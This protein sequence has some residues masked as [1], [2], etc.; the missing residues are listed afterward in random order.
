MGWKLCRCDFQADT[1]IALICQGS[2]D[3]CIEVV[4]NDSDLLAYESIQRLT[5]PV[6]KHRELTTFEKRNVLSLLKLRSDRHLLLVCILTKNDYFEGIS[7][8]GVFNNADIVRD[9]WLD[10]VGPVKEVMEN[11]VRAY[12]QKIAHPQTEFELYSNA[13]SA[14]VDLHE[15]P[16]NDATPSAQTSDWVGSVLQQIEK[17]KQSRIH[18]EPQQSQAQEGPSQLRW[19]RSKYKSKND[20]I[21]P[22]YT[23]HTVKD[24]H[25]APKVDPK[26]LKK[27]KVDPPRPPKQSSNMM[28]VNKTT[29]TVT[30]P[31]PSNPPPKDTRI[32]PGKPDET[33]ESKVSSHLPY[34]NHDSRHLDG[35]PAQSDGHE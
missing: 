28:S 13:L 30:V 3:H 17:H 34:D 20:G 14:F 18:K 2:P 24:I 15:S 4:S 29:A 26:Q 33:V 10:P 8:L 16:S 35:M 7:G 1:C 25:Q 22:R 11:G 19:R 6:G 9:I 21:R 23:A 32:R 12:L 27:M 5:M 31:P